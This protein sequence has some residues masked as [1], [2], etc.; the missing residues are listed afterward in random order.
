MASEN[1]PLAAPVTADANVDVVDDGSAA[2]EIVGDA[3]QTILETDGD[4]GES[5]TGDGD[6]DETDGEDE[7][8]AGKHEKLPEHVQKAVDARI[9]KVVGKQKAAE[10]ERDALKA[11]RDELKASFDKVSDDSVL[12]TAQEAGVLTD[13]LDKTDAERIG[14][15][16]TAKES[17]RYFS[18]WLEDNPYA[19]A[20]LELNG[21]EYNRAEIRAAKRQWQEKL[22]G[23]EDMP[24]RMKELRERSR[25]IV[26]L[27][28]AAQKAGWKPGA[29]APAAGTKPPL[30]KPI[31][32]PMANAA[33][34]RTS[35]GVGK[36]SLDPDAVKG[37]D[38][39]VRLIERGL[40]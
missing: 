12:R 1:S 15:Y 36:P 23:L 30:P 33:A 19:E 7:E 4:E 26:R 14:T 25:E 9:A 22:D 3:D 34:P 39:L 38:D 35:P 13:L 29:K 6:G 40:K 21:R 11:E 17:V 20:T 18:D 31:G 8:A 24:G 27:G 37:T 28:I 5:G 10:Q 16:R 32:K 2:G